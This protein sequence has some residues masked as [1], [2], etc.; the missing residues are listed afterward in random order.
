MT[1]S[2][3]GDDLPIT[4]PG[5]LARPFVLVVRRSGDPVAVV[6]R[7]PDRRGDTVRNGRRRCWRRCRLRTAAGPAEHSASPSRTAQRHSAPG[8]GNGG[9]YGVDRSASEVV[10]AFACGSDVRGVGPGWTT[11]QSAEARRETGSV[12]G[13]AACRLEPAAGGTCPDRPLS[14]TPILR[15]GPAPPRSA[16]RAPVLRSDRETPVAAKVAGPAHAQSMLHAPCAD[17]FDPDAFSARTS[18]QTQG[19]PGRAAGASSIVYSNAKRASTIGRSHCA[20][21]VL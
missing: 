18:S 6:G 14:E 3:R 12:Q 13:P 21:A 19:C 4:R 10:Q 8:G 11:L 17:L 9:T 7:Q 15:D 5:C 1:V 20:F 2:R 16:S